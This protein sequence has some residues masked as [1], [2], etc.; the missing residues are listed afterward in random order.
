MKG[1]GL[2]AIF[3]HCC[4][5]NLGDQATGQELLLPWEVCNDIGDNSLQGKGGAGDSN[6]MAKGRVRFRPSL[7]AAG[8]DRIIW[9]H[10]NGRVHF[11]V[12]VFLV[13]RE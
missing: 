10:R 7:H 2:C 6:V 5:P 11:H 8:V 12:D 13:R 3:V 1:D 9:I 4:T